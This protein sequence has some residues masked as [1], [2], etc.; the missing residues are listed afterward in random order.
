M[1]MISLT[2]LSKNSMSHV[3]AGYPGDWQ[4]A[5]TPDGGASWTCGCG[6]YFANQGG[7]SVGNNTTSNKSGNLFSP[8]ENPRDDD[9]PFECFM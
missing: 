4:G 2:E 6:C 5:Y 7:S 8:L 3:L 1:K 9:N